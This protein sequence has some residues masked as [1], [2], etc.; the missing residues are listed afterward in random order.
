MFSQQFI[1]NTVGI[2]SQAEKIR[3]LRPIP[4]YAGFTVLWIQRA[5]RGKRERE[6]CREEKKVLSSAQLGKREGQKKNLK[7]S[8]D[9]GGKRL[10]TVLY[11]SFLFSP[12]H[13]IEH[14]STFPRS[15][16]PL[17]FYLLLFFQVTSLACPRIYLLYVHGR[18]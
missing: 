3:F 11:L 10:C 8:E 7:F 6:S 1:E 18:P 4:T 13:R 16:P 9:K 2:L 12:R 14:T 5:D 15:L 17:F